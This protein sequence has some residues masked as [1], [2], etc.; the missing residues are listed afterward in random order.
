MWLGS[1][2]RR[3]GFGRVAGEHPDIR[4][5]AP[6]SRDR[7]QVHSLCSGILGSG[8][9]PATHVHVYSNAPSVALLVNGKQVT[10]PQSMEFFGTATG[11]A[12]LEELTAVAMDDSG[13]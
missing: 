2:N 6:G 9:R 5:R 7:H 11:G 1:R 3:A 10:D 8:G 12:L 4:C 13:M